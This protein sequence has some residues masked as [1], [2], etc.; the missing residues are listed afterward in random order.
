MARNFDIVPQT[1]R[2]PIASG[3][4]ASAGFNYGF[5]NAGSSMSTSALAN[6]AMRGAFQTSANTTSTSLQ[7]VL[8]YTGQGYVDVL[9]HIT[10]ALADGQLKVTVDGVVV[11]DLTASSTRAY[12]AVGAVEI[13]TGILSG[14]A[15]TYFNVTPGTPIPFNSSILIEHKVNSGAQ[16]CYTYYRVVKTA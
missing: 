7:T 6:G 4:T 5:D 16:A 8:S 1:S 10:S 14:S 11:L 2:L 12:S 3:I 13:G 9:A 15:S